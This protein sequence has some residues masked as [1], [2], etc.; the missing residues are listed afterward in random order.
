M[1]STHIPTLEPP[2]TAVN[3]ELYKAEQI[4]HE[5]GTFGL[6]TKANRVKPIIGGNVEKYT[7]VQNDI[8]LKY[9]AKMMMAKTDKD[10]DTAYNEFL[11][12]MKVR[13]HDSDTS[14]EFGKQYQEYGNTPAGKINVTVSK[15]MPRNV[16]SDKAEVIGR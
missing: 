5:Q 2:W 8:R 7:P 16:F 14:E 15:Y 13:G 4:N 3:A 1:G 12:E 6:V 11:N 10:F 9:Y